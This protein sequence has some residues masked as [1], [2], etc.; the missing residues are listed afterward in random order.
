MKYCDQCGTK[1]NDNV[2]FCSNCGARITSPVETPVS[3]SYNNERQMHEIQTSDGKRLDIV[4]YLRRLVLLEKTIYTQK[5]I[6]AQMKS[7][8]NSLGYS[9]TY[10]KPDLPRYSSW[11]DSL[12]EFPYLLW[13][14]GL[15]A[16]IGG[17]VG[18]LVSRLYIR[19]IIIGALIGGV[20]GLI[21]LIV[22]FILDAKSCSEYNAQLAEEYQY[23]LDCYHDALAADRKRV[24]QELEQKKKLS[25][26][27]NEMIKK[28]EE[29]EYVL[30]QYYKKDI[31]FGK[32]RNLVAVCS[33][34]EYFISGRCSTLTGHEG[35]YNI[36]ENEIRLNGIYNRLDLVIEYLEDIKTNQ[37]MI[38]E[39]IQE[40]N[41]VTQQLV[42]ESVRQSKL[43]ENVLEN[44]VIASHYAKIA[45]DN[46]EACKWL[47]IEN[48]FAIKE[49]RQ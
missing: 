13:V 10:Q 47:G 23:N 8:I 5:Q 38:Y 2:K 9:Y 34:Y 4:E 31:I 33:F 41:C 12:N 3:S 44:V 6:I 1:L 32:Y 30:D 26:I 16:F 37:H 17:F 48:Y 22:I 28:K 46:S 45:A 39:A 36:Y 49:G 19:P 11:S 35:A 27:L 7:Q 21:F 43:A 15:G 18:L 29:T 42:K 14:I 40:G 20:I 25:E 24:E